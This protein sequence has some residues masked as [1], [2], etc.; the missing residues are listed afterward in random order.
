[1][2]YTRI[3]AHLAKAFTLGA[4]FYNVGNDASRALNNPALF[5]CALSSMFYVGVMPTIISCNHS[6]LF[7]LLELKNFFIVSVPLQ[8]QLFKG[9]FSNCWYSLESYFLAS[10]ISQIPLLL[11][12]SSL[13]MSIVYWMS[14]QPND[15]FIFAVSLFSAFMTC[16][17]SSSLGQMVGIIFGMTV[18]ENFA[19]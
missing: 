3:I 18:S 8:K 14:G 1:V 15:L 11:F 12:N 6:K 13:F 5:T 17:I 9:E 16:L 2:I 7:L 4:L 10:F 19:K